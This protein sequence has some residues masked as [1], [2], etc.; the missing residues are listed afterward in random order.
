M[1]SAEDIL[2]D[3]KKELTRIGSTRQRDYDLLK[4]KK[5]VRSTTI[6]RRLKLSWPEVVKLTDLKPFPLRKDD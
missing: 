4:G 2:K 3:L 5:R 6:C 1:K